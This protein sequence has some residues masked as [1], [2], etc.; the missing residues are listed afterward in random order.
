MRKSVV[1]LGLGVILG[2]VAAAGWAQEGTGS[3]HIV[4]KPADVKW[5]EGPPSLPKGALFVVVSGD[6]GKPGPFTIR[7]KVP[8]GYKIAPHWHPT[9]ENVTVLSGTFAVGMG[10]KADMAALQ[11]L[12]AGSYA[13]MP[14]EMRHY[15]MAR[16]AVV[17]EVYG[18][19]PFAL[20]YVNPADDPRQA[21]SAK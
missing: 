16:T 7:L 2:V 5:G 21:A 15:A 4:L 6:P 8:A 3:T 12:P 9:D 17:V 19:G 20:N 14:A 11:D 18:L 1:C 13:R 10:D